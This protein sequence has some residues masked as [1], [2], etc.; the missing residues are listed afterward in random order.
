MQWLFPKLHLEPEVLIFFNSAAAGQ[1][2][3]ACELT[4]SDQSQHHMRRGQWEGTR[5]TS[6]GGSKHEE[7]HDTKRRKNNAQRN[8]SFRATDGTQRRRDAVPTT[9]ARRRAPC[10]PI[11]TTRRSSMVVRRI[12]VRRLAPG[13]GSLSDSGLR[14]TLPPVQVRNAV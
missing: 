4:S 7:T 3:A 14:K 13:R 5:N 2:A 6:C 12:S 10:S 9:L 8:E 11:A 1:S